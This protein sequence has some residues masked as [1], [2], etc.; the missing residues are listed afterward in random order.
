VLELDGAVLAVGNVLSDVLS[1]AG[2]VSGPEVI[3]VTVTIG[4]V[5][6]EFFSF[7]PLP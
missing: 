7:S 3:R 6:R 5:V 1:I 2:L 4:V